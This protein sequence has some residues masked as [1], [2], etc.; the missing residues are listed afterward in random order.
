[1]YPKYYIGPM[2]KNVVDSII[3][4]TTETNKNYIC[5]LFFFTKLLY[6]VKSPQGPFM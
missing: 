1:M 4:F 6:K 2:T 3:E 5:H